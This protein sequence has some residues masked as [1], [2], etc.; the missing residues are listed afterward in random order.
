[1]DH[2]QHSTGRGW[3][4]ICDR[5][6]VGLIVFQL[7]TAGQLALKGAVKRSVL[8][9]PLLIATVWFSIVYSRTY[10]PLMKYI[11]LRSVRKAEHSDLGHAD[12]D[13]PADADLADRRYNS[14]TRNG[15]TVDESRERGLRFINPS[16][17]AP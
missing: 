10:K 16:L 13:A 14:E 4:M 11:A 12:E 6:I 7:T 2:R 1:M 5:V 17:I 8:I 9:V 3:T 15:Q